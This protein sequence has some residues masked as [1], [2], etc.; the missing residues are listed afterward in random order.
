MDISFCQLSLSEAAALM[1]DDRDAAWAGRMGLACLGLSPPGSQLCQTLCLPRRA[2][3]PGLCPCPLWHAGTEQP[4]GRAVTQLLSTG[5]A[6]PD[7][8][9]KTQEICVG[10]VSWHFGFCLIRYAITSHT[11]DALNW[12][13]PTCE[14]SL[15]T[16]SEQLWLYCTAYIQETDFFHCWRS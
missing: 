2:L 12:Q 7:T 11:S 3:G 4:Q 8:W 16:V 13:F 15:G 6:A 1:L 5:Q 10:D 14:Q 9:S